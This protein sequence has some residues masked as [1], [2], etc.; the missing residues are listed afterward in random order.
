M[1]HFLTAGTYSC[2]VQVITIPLLVGETCLLV[3]TDNL[4]DSQRKSC[5]HFSERTAG[6]L[7]NGVDR[8]GK[9]TGANALDVSKITIDGGLLIN[10]A[11]AVALG[12][13]HIHDEVVIHSEVKSDGVKADGSFSQHAGLLYNGNYGKD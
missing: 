5:T 7:I 9:M 4:S 11:S 10:N 1:L 12:Y 3:G 6:T 2:T 13:E 8:I